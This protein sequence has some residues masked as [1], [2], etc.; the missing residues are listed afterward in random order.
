VRVLILA[1]AIGSVPFMLRAQEPGAP[2][3]A[4]TSVPAEPWI[5]AAVDA[6]QRGKAPNTKLVHPAGMNSG[7]VLFGSFSTPFTRVTAAAAAAK[8]TYKTFT[9][10]DV[11][12]DLIAPELHV[13]VLSKPWGIEAARVEAVVIT[14]A[15]GKEDEKR[16]R[17]I[18]PLRLEPTPAMFRNLLGVEFEG[19]HV[20]A[21]FPLSA[22]SEANEVHVV[23]AVPVPGGP[24]G[25]VKGCRDC[26][27]TFSLKDVRVR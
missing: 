1:L 11:T 5:A 21:V 25:D 10:A 16:A 15:K 4:P 2:P 3:A 14:P 9:V 12:P 22:L 17:A 23:Y 19:E 6:G 27:D 7:R 20:L 24:D 26:H 8:R 13:Y 18:Q